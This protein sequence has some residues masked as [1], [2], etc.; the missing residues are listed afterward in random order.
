MHPSKHKMGMYFFNNSY[1]SLKLLEPREDVR[2]PFRSVLN[3]VI[4]FYEI[5]LEVISQKM[6][7]MI[8]DVSYKNIRVQSKILLK[9]CD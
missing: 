7:R 5:N 8:L 1:V 4:F 3:M 2:I 6:R 9:R